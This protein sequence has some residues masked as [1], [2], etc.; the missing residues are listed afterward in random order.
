MDE[1]EDWPREAATLWAVYVYICTY[2]CIIMYCLS[3]ACGEREVA[4]LWA[5]VDVDP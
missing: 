5:V 3:K 2:A 4:V 1:T